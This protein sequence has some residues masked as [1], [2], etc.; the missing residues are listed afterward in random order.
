MISATFALTPEIIFSVETAP[1]FKT[2]SS[3]ER[4]PLTCTILLC[5]GLPSRT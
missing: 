4:A 2:E 3:T 5:G 1:F